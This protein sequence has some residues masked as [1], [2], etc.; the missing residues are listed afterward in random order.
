M[1]KSKLKI[2]LLLKIIKIRLPISYKL[3]LTQGKTALYTMAYIVIECKFTSFNSMFPYKK[4]RFSRAKKM[5]SLIVS[6]LMAQSQLKCIP[7]KRSPT[8]GTNCIAISAQP[9]FISTSLT[10][11][12]EHAGG[13]GHFVL[14]D[15][16]VAAVVVR[17]DPRD[18]ELHAGLQTIGNRIMYTSRQSVNKQ[19]SRDRE[20][21]RNSTH[22]VF[23]GFYDRDAVFVAVLQ[24]PSVCSLPVPKRLGE[25]FNFALQSRSRVAVGRHGLPV[26]ANQGRNW[27]EKYHES[28]KFFYLISVRN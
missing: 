1:P 27:K 11:H 8:R 12:G 4:N 16:V 20:P 9:A 21:M 14:T 5:R 6:L 28:S 10:K 2:Q 7:I 13:L 23:A 25:C 17:V 26:D 3:L 18:V 15:A 24:Q 19:T 22:L